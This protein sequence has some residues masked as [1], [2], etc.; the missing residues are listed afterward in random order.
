MSGQ[1]IRFTPFGPITR[2]WIGCFGAA[3]FLLALQNLSQWRDRHA[4]M[5]NVSESLPNFALWVKLGVVPK[6]GE[7]IIFEAP[8]T[9]M[10]KVHFSDPVPPFGKKVLGVGGDVV[11]HNGDIVRI[12]GEI[13]AQRKAYTKLGYPLTRGPVGVIPKG[14][15]YAGSAHP[16]GFDS[17]YAEI[18]FVC[19]PQLIGQGVG[20]L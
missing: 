14:C 2:R 19:R 11:S 10:L 6:K 20:I 8:P 15:F 7:V 17:R 3:F 12:N 1:L 18:G 4:F 13:V 16:D 5:I 9:K